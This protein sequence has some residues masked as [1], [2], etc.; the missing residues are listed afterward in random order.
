MKSDM[1][2]QNTWNFIKLNLIKYIRAENKFIL[3][4]F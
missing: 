3:Q 4:S 2:S 1:K